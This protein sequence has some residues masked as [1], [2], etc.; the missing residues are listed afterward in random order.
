MI[1]NDVLGY[2]RCYFTDEEYNEH[3]NEIQL[4]EELVCSMNM[5]YGD[6]DMMC[7]LVRHYLK[8]KEYDNG[9]SSDHNS[10]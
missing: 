6:L 3:I 8:I 1:D 10:D 7:Y 2:I 5:S 9:K 4:L